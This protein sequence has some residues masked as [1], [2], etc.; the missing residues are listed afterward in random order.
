MLNLRPLLTGIITSNLFFAFA[1]SAQ[2]GA[3][4][5]YTGKQYPSVNVHAFGEARYYSETPSEKNDVVAGQQGLHLTAALTDRISGFGEFS[6]TFKESDVH[7][8]VERMIV[9]YD[10]SDY[11]KLSLG[12]YHTPIGFWNATYHHGA[13]LQTTISRPTLMKFGSQIVPIHFEG[14]LAEGNLPV[15]GF[16]LGYRVGT[17]TGIHNNITVDDN[18]GHHGETDGDDAFTLQ[19]YTRPSFIR[20]MEYGLSYYS[21]TVNIE[22]E[23][24]HDDEP[25][26]EHI[27]GLEL[28]HHGIDRDIKEKTFGL[29]FA[30]EQ[31]SIEII[32]ELIYWEH[33]Y[34]NGAQGNNYGSGFYIQ[35]ARQMEGRFEAFKPY[36]RLDKINADHDDILFAKDQSFESVTLGVRYDLTHSTALKVEYRNEQSG[37]KDRLNSLVLQLSIVLPNVFSF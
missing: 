21:D 32:S 19:L 14:V 2:T 5:A 13:W 4:E 35:A 15:N 26:D 30:L 37:D 8:D 1:A 11:L 28:D 18:S 36:V 24:I 16:N 23:E 34:D 27:D 10:F 25:I 29:H 12:R 33:E 9:R 31:E 3:P 7:T 17:G 22:S 6:L 20:G